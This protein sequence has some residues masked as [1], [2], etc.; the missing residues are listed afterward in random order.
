MILL[1]MLI[2]SSPS[3]PLLL[4]LLLLLLS[5]GRTPELRSAGADVLRA[6]VTGEGTGVTFF[7][8][9]LI[10]SVSDFLRVNKN[11]LT[12]FSELVNM[13]GF[14]GGTGCCCCVCLLLSCFGVSSPSSEVVA[15]SAEDEAEAE[16][17]ASLSSWRISCRLLDIFSL[18]RSALILSSRRAA[19]SLEDLW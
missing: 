18:V 16:G 4:L 15:S 6:D 10:M 8:N 3:L 2:F 12:Y 11:L 13:A 14:T 17:E 5:E 19:R 7:S 1:E 9:C